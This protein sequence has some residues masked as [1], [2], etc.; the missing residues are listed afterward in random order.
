MK[1]ETKYEL[2]GSMIR[3]SGASWMK[4]KSLSRLG[5]TCS[6][7]VGC[8]YLFAS[9]AYLMQP[10]EMRYHMAEFW[11]LFIEN[12]KLRMVHIIYHYNRALGALLAIAA[13]MA[14][15]EA[16]RHAD[17]GWIRWTR[18]L[19]Y[20][21]FAMEAILNFRKAAFEL[22]NAEAYAS[23]DAAT[24]AAI[25]AAHSWIDLDAQGLIRYGTVGLWILVISFVALRK[26][27]LSKRLNYVGIIVAPIYWYSGIFG[28]VFQSYELLT[29]TIGVAGVTLIP[30]WYISTGLKLLKVKPTENLELKDMSTG[31][32]DLLTRSVS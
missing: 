13:V 2:G 3:D 12:A 18:N 14:I 22:M 32:P 17:E 16:V 11:P 10:V 19:A 24:R 9:V 30:I 25:V 29:I 31:S 4:N 7:L 21:G 27:I 5:G 1:V 20:L 26:G 15:S 8:S 6:I 23:G 28:V